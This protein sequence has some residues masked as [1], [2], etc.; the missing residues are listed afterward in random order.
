MHSSFGTVLF[1]YGTVGLILFI[2][3]TCIIIRGSDLTVVFIIGIIFIFSLSHNGLR[4]SAFWSLFG[5]IYVFGAGVSKQVRSGP[6]A[7]HR[8]SPTIGSVEGD[9]QATRGANGT[10]LCRRAPLDVPVIISRR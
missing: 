5:L 6:G 9:P 2:Y 4:F 10:D 1:S 7:T 3:L 8:R